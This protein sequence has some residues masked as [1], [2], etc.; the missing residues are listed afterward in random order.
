MGLDLYPA[1]RIHRS[2]RRLHR[3]RNLRRGVIE[4]EVDTVLTV[5]GFHERE[6]TFDWLADNYMLRDNI[7]LSAH[8]ISLEAFHARC[9]TCTCTCKY[10]HHCSAVV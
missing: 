2:K 3:H 5:Y 9:C 10:D 8:Y 1:T 4:G 7:L 6:L